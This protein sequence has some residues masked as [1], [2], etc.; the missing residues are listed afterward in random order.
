MNYP[1][2]SIITIT[3]NL[4]SENRIDLFKKCLESVHNQMYP[5]I[6]HIIIDGNS[7]DGTLDILQHYKNM[8]WIK[9]YSEPD[10]GIDDAYN[11]GNKRASGKYIGWMN[12]DDSYCD[13]YSVMNCIKSLEI[14]NGDYCY[15]KQVNVNREGRKVS[16]FIPRIENFWKDMPFSHQTMFVKKSVIEELGGYNTDYGF[17]GD[18]YLVLQLILNDYIGIYVNE[19]ISK[20][21]LGGFSSSYEDKFRVYLCVSILSKRLTL[22]YKEF[23]PTIDE[24]E[25]QNIYWNGEDINIYPRLFL[26]KMIRYLVEKRLKNFNYNLFI[27]YVNGI[28]KK[29]TVNLELTNSCE[30]QEK[31]NGF[32]ILKDKWMLKFLKRSEQFNITKMPYFFYKFFSFYCK[33]KKCFGFLRIR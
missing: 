6:E 31:Q 3:Y 12:S 14:N 25:A 17:G 1:L 29:N 18:F 11:K 20:Y 30:K 5:N 10:D 21:T 7:L 23:Y 16:E 13:Q 2:V 22:F 4:V 26:Q 33:A 24:D 28:I 32:P 8:G 19:F 15:G 9:Y 27:N